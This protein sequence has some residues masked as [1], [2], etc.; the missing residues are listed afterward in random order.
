[1]GGHGEPGHEQQG[2]GGERQERPQRVCEETPQGPPT[3]GAQALTHQVGRWDHADLLPG[4]LTHSRQVGE[5]KAP[6]RDRCQ[7]MRA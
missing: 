3:L 6:F 4:T 1:M 5:L 2:W 7:A